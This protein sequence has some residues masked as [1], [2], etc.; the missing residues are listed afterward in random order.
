MN[1]M[2][3]PS[4]LELA[5]I[6]MRTAGMY[7][8]WPQPEPITSP[9]PL[10]KP[11]PLD[12]LGKTLGEA[13]ATIAKVVKAPPALAA[14]SVIG[15]AALACQP[16]FNAYHLT[17]P[18]G[19]PCSLNL[20][21]QADSGDRKTSCDDL[22]LQPIKEREREAFGRYREALKQAQQN[23]DM[24]QPTNPRRLFSEPTWEYIAS[25]MVGG[26]YPSAGLFSDEGGGF[27]G[28]HSM[29]AETRTASLA[30]LVQL[31][32]SGKVERLR[33]TEKDSAG[34][35]YDRRLSVHLMGQPITLRTSLLDPVLQGQGFLPRFLFV[36]PQSIAGTRL[37]NTDEIRCNAT[38]AHRLHAYWGRLSELLDTTA[39][40]TDDGGL[41]PTPLDVEPHALEYWVEAFNMVESE[42]GADGEYSG[43][44]KPFASRFGE[45]ALRLSTVLA[46]FDGLDIVT[47][48]AMRHACVLAMFSLGEWQRLYVSSEGDR[49]TM[50][51]ARLLEWLKSHPAHR[52]A[53]TL[54]IA[55]PKPRLGIRT[56]RQRLEYLEDSGWVRN[57][58]EGFSEFI[59][60]GDGHA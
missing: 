41:S 43:P 27:L 25:H 12:A 37:I 42:Q 35:A 50:E 4:A 56:I 29:K 32:D 40:M 18:H 6:N 28:G 24:Q 8:D 38:A 51:A 48:R 16:L 11:Y 14:H 33:R 55:G 15:A 39:A 44:M 1:N 2:V 17:R 21:T 52:S 36:A 10:P 5:T 53:R 30:G 26:G 57:L 34:T 60:W 45:H 31:Y 19:Q 3:Q 20:L 46:G 9:Q 13:A 49:E 47:E 59:V 23:P 58:G 54:A 7:A 22:A